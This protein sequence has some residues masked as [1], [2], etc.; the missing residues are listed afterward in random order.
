[1]ALLLICAD[2]ENP[3]SRVFHHWCAL[4]KDEGPCKALKDRFYFNSDTLRC[5]HFEYGGCQGNAN[6]FMTLEEC[7]EMCLVKGKRGLTTF[8]FVLLKM[9]VTV[10]SKGKE[11]CV[12][13]QGR[14]VEADRKWASE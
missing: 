5:E 11:R 4:K 14:S 10:L 8:F 2:R 1:M 13:L 12:R 7:E 9:K 6:N 3:P